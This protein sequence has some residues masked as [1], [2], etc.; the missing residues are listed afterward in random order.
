M[1][2]V[3]N[4]MIKTVINST[5]DDCNI[6]TGFGFFRDYRDADEFSVETGKYVSGEH[7]GTIYLRKE[8]NRRQNIQL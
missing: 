6:E 3:K 1:K 5:D 2:W 4:G 8:E 7:I